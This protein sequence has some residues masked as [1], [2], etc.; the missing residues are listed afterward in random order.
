MFYISNYFRL[1]QIAPQITIETHSRTQK[2]DGCS[3]TEEFLQTTVVES[4]LK[5]SPSDSLCSA[6]PTAPC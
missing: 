6:L 5:A 4:G 2:V 3:E 1:F